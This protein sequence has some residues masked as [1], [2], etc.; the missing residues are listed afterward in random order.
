[1]LFE[2]EAIKNG[3]FEDSV[4]EASKKS[5]IDSLYGY[6]DNST[7]ID[8]WYSREIGEDISPSEAAELIKKLTRKEIIEAAKGI[9]LHTI[10]RLLPKEANV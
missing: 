2:L 9:K 7:A 4:I 3:D 1:M 10:Y 8:I 6:Y 5:I